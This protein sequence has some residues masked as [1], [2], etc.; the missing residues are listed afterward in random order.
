M[1][2]STKFDP[3]RDKILHFSQRI[4]DCQC[5]ISQTTCLTRFFWKFFR[6]V[7]QG[8]PCGNQP[9]SKTQ[10]RGLGQLN[11][12]RFQ[13]VMAHFLQKHIFNQIE[14]TTKFKIDFHIDLIH[15]TL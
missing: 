12:V 13:C 10:N 5:K 11:L 3:L 14:G 7:T 8:V 6:K 15:P 4:R 9:Y 2:K 1:T